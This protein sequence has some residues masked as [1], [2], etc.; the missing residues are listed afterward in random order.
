MKNIFISTVLLI[1][2]STMVFA[3]DKVAGTWDASIETDNGPFE[4]QIIYKVEGA[5]ISGQFITDMGDLEFGH[6]KIDGKEFEYEFEFDYTTYTHKGKLVNKDEI[7][8][9]Q[10]KD[11]ETTE[12]TV[13]RVKE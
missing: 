6:G 2:C 10:T 8:I 7:L 11:G 3:A 12:F 1:F 9:K 13:K 4:F 5:V